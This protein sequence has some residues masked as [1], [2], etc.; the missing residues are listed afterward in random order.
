MSKKRNFCDYCTCESCKNGTSYLWN[1]STVEDKMICD[2][3]YQYE[4]CMEAQIKETGKHNG[5][6]SGKCKHRPKL[7]SKWKKFRKT[8]L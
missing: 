8:T 1:A 6:C 5:P 7:T 4:V 2:V 3:C